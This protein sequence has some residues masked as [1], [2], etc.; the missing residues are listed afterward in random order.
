MKKNSVYECRTA[1]L[2]RGGEAYAEEIAMALYEAYNN[3]LALPDISKYNFGF[4]PSK[5]W[6]NFFFQIKNV[7]TLQK[8]FGKLKI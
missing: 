5:K 6:K 8:K 1:F 2:G 7:T 4:K 3:D